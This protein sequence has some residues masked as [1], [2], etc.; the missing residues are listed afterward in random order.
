MLVIKTFD[1]PALYH[2]LLVQDLELVGSAVTLLPGYT[3][4]TLS[5]PLCNPQFATEWVGFEV[6]SDHPDNLGVS[7][8]LVTASGQPRRYNV[9]SETWEPSAT[10]SFVTP[11]QL[12]SWLP[13]W[14]GNT[15]LRLRLRLTATPGH[16]PEVYWVRLGWQ[17]PL[18]FKS[19]WTQHALPEYLSQP[20]EMG[21]WGYVDASGVNAVC[22]GIRDLPRDRI[23]GL[24][25]NGF[26]A[27]ISETGDLLLQSPATPE[28]P[29]FVR[30]EFR[31]PIAISISGM[32]QLEHVPVV[33]IQPTQTMPRL[34]E[35]LQ[36]IRV[37][38]D[39][40]GA[41]AIDAEWLQIHDQRYEIQVIA[42]REIEA[43][44]IASALMAHIRATR[45]APV[46]AFGVDL[47][48]QEIGQIYTVSSPPLQ[49]N[50][51]ALAF[52]I[53][54]KGLFE[55]EIQRRLPLVQ[56]ISFNAT[57]L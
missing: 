49:G 26:V 45:L 25:A 42:D 1:L 16:R 50:G 19:Y 15:P 34:P 10:V 7:V 43:R 51:A 12:R 17:C 20:C 23:T 24:R 36:G 22:E 4:G 52:Q 41:W 8:A 28:A 30:W 56:S 44:S 35:S 47:V 14:P 33:V 18:N 3:V 48:I 46:P 13:K 40:E 11:S 5:L 38:D 57:T 39:D 27:S 9:T 31:P 6:Y 55:A 32:L 21:A 2:T 54:A 29:I 37:A 53:I